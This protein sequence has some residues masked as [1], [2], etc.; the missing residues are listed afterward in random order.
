VGFVAAT[1]AICTTDDIPVQPPAPDGFY[2][3]LSCGVTAR[4]A[5]GNNGAFSHRNRTQ[6]AYDF[7]LGLNTPLTAMADGT[8][9]HV[10]DQTGP[11]DNCYNGG[12]SDCFPYANLVVLLHGDGTTTIYKHLNR[13]DVSLGEA[14]GRG[15]AVGLSGST[16]YSTGPHAHV[17]RQEGC[18]EANCQSLPLDFVGIGVPNTDDMV[19]SNNCP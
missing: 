6:Y 7:S 14:V 17:M 4:I 16:G 3:P 10:Y 19:T 9:L 18:G 12:N 2:V 11:G 1:F 13:V 8:V 5:Q 15:T